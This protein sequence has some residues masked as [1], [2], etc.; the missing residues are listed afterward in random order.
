[1]IM[2]TI[3]CTLIIL[4]TLGLVLVPAVAE[5][6]PVRLLIGKRELPVSPAAVYDGSRV[7]APMAV[8][9]LLGVNS[10]VSSDGK[11]VSIIGHGEAFADVGVV[12]VGT[13]RMVCLD[14]VLKIVGGEVRANADDRSAAIRANLTAVEFTDGALRV[15]CTLP[16]VCSV[17]LW[18][19]RMIVDVS[20]TKLATETKEVYVG[21]DIVNK[22]RLGQYTDDTARIVLDLS[23]PGGYK[24]ES[25][26]PSS[27][28]LIRIAEDLPLSLP[29]PKNPPAPA[30]PF[31]ITGIRVESVSD[32][33]FDL[34]IDTSERGSVD[35]SKSAFPSEVTLILKGGRL[36]QDVTAV[37]GE[38]PML[39]NA[40]FAQG[41]ISPPMARVHMNLKRPVLTS[42]Q[43]ADSEIRVKVRLPDKAG[44]KLEGMLVVIDPGH[45]GSQPGATAGGVK[46]KEVNLK[47]GQALA[48]ALQ[49]AGV[50]TMFTRTTDVTMDL[51]PRPAVAQSNS[52]DF[53]ISLHC[54]SNIKPDSTSGI[55]TYHYRVGESSPLLARAI[56]KEVCES[57]G[58][59]NRGAHDCGFKVLRLL[60]GTGIPCV[61][62]E[63]GYLNH[64]RDRARL[65]NE[66]YRQKLAEGIVAGLRAY[67]EGTQ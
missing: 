18:D 15:N 5:D 33:Q 30:R 29:Q 35:I 6:V 56:Q 52:A 39:A 54:N 40:R 43:V 12:E 58:M 2:R 7:L 16:V 19:G 26:L 21:G 42:V 17:S 36:S 66:A 28:L 50:R 27:Q 20:G 65:T 37:T 11:T 47:L 23:K 8:L 63:C 13:S 59:C 60:E 14:D 25:P 45:G 44:G 57:T 34:V 41:S 64:S 1:M 9:G 32:T 10:A 62:V 31:G 55:E 38:H 67:V 53:F 51:A 61:L 46:E 3:L 48:E 22:L 4:S 49:K 24:I